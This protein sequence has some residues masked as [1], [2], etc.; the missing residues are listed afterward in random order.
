MAYPRSTNGIE[1][2]F[3]YGEE[4]QDVG[5]D[6]IH[7]EPIRE[8]SMRHHW[9]I[10]PHRHPNHVQIMLFTKGGAQT[11]LDGRD[12]SPEAGSVILHPA[13][14]VHSIRYLEGTEGLTITVAV[15]ALALMLRETT[16]LSAVIAAPGVIRLGDREGAVRTAFEKLAEEYRCR[17]PAWEVAARACLL[18]ILVQLHRVRGGAEDRK[19]YR[20]GRE[21]A[22]GLARLI[23]ENFRAQKRVS[24]YARMLCISPQRLNAACKSALGLSASEMLYA[25]IMLEARRAL[26]FSDLTIG[27]IAHDLGY[28]DPAYFNRFFSGRAGMPPGE[29][30]TRF[31]ETELT[32][33]QKQSNSPM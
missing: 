21:L 22:N 11:H 33:T 6:T 16:A 13:G 9:I 8:R 28:D 32:A 19:S 7:I 23:E 5:F 4:A 1:N 20:R 15:S 17:E 29:W 27:E 2:V 30:R 31:A 24:S 26:A 25:R 18:D 10:Q 3:L 14:M 12:C